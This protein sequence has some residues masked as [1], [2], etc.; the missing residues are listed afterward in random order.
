MKQ[1]PRKSRV[2]TIERQ[3]HLKSKFIDFKTNI[4]SGKEAALF[5]FDGVETG[6][7]PCGSYC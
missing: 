1:N 4:V 6:T 2:K 5:L 3:K 7:G